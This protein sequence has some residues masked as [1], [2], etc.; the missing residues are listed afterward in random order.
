MT[1]NGS[2][3]T[4]VSLTTSWQRLSLVTSQLNPQFGF[5]MATAGDEI[6]VDYVSLVAEINDTTPVPDGQASRAAEAIRWLVPASWPTART[7]YIDLVLPRLRANDGLVIWG[8][9]EGANDR[10]RCYIAANALDINCEVRIAGTNVATLNLGP[11]VVGSNK[12]AFAVDAAS[13]GVLRLGG[14]VQSHNAAPSSLSSFWISGA[15]ARRA[16]L[17]V[18]RMRGLVSRVSNA[19]LP[20]GLAAW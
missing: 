16:T 11:A 7:V 19:A 10:L 13:V 14:A 9:S 5:R 8:A 3:W 17:N 20:G 12:L 4:A 18:P 2:T 1:Q 15:F 6:E